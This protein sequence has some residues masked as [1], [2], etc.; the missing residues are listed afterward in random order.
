MLFGRFAGTFHP[1]SLLENRWRIPDVRICCEH[2][3]RDGALY[4]PCI[5][6]T[7]S[8]TTLRT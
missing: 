8:G 4:H 2:E 6:I 5:P 1:V 7:L 3:V